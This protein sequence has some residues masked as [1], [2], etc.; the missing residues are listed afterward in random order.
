MNA[1]ILAD[2][3]KIVWMRAMGA[4]APAARVFSI[5]FWGLRKGVRGEPLRGGVIN[6]V[7]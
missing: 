1:M 2:W 6:Y 3:G 5:A 7:L 4:G